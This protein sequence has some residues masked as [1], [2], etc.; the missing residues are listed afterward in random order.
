MQQSRIFKK[1][2]ILSS[3]SV[4]SILIIQLQV[5]NA[6]LRVTRKDTTI[7]YVHMCYRGPHIDVLNQP[8]IRTS[9]PCLG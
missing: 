1:H 7:W 9:V 2:L 8:D 4:S 3:I 5:T 6:K